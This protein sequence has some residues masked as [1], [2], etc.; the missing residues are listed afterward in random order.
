MPRPLYPGSNPLPTVEKAAGGDSGSVWTS[1]KILPPLKFKP[2]TVQPVASGYTYY[3]KHGIKYV[4]Q[5]EYKILLM[6][7]H[8]ALM[9]IMPTVIIIII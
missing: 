8:I 2:L 4:I 6:T 3:Q 5:E 7:S 1:A 9:A